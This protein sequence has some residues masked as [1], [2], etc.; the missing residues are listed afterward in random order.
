MNT[1]YTKKLIALIS[2][3]ILCI[4]IIKAQNVIKPAAVIQIQKTDPDQIKST[5]QK[6]PRQQNDFIENHRRQFLQNT[7]KKESFSQPNNFSKENY[8][9]KKTNGYSCPPRLETNFEGN[10]L[11]PFYLP[12][13]GYYASESSIAV[14]NSG[15]I[16]SISN[17]WIRYYNTDGAL[18]FSDSLYHFCSG[19]IDVRVMYDPQKDR[20]VFISAY[21]VTDFISLF[22]GYGIVAA[23]SK[24]SDPMDGWNFY[25]LPDSLSNDNSGSDYPQL[26]ISNDEVFIT[27][28]RTDEDGN[29]TH[30]R[31]IQVNKNEGYAG[32]ASL[33]MQTFSVALSAVTQGSVVP[34]SGGSKPYGPNM[35]FMMADETG[36]PDDIYHVFEI[37][38]TIA[39]G[40]AMLKTYG[41]VHS[42]ETY[43]PAPLSYQPGP[44]PL[45]EQGTE[46]GPPGIDDYLQNA[47]FE[48]GVLQFSQ[49]SAANGKA[50][51]CIGRINGIPN[52]L[53]CNTQTI[54]DL[55]LSLLFPQIAYTGN[56]CNDN[57]FIVGIEYTGEKKY[58]GLEAVSVDNYFSVSRPTIVK[59]GED[60]INGLWGD[61]SGICR[62]YNH[63]GECWMEGQYGSKIFPN[64]NWIAKLQ[65][66]LCHDANALLANNSSDLSSDVMAMKYSLSNYPNPFSN[67]A[68]I[69][70]SLAQSQKVSI[71]IFDMTGRLIKT[72]ADAQMEAGTH[73]LVW[74][75][76]DEKGNE[77]SSGLYF[78]RMQT[79]NYVETKKLSVLK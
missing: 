10:P 29:I 70:F 4:T 78:L 25:Y 50:A 62:R 44:L 75:A 74:N 40:K 69:S 33:K 48:N 38:N 6:S 28:L 8:Q 71:R 46:L 24:T 41:P 13:V 54:R 21:G 64:I 77:V 73:Q 3:S 27:D 9:D 59:H 61:Y 20:F 18:T 19:L 55:H 16:V 56:S 11:T 63:P 36:S 52:H 23:F 37:T 43:F 14:S 66:P 12:P 34:A 67:S 65:A 30:S 45:Y 39:S 2:V 76:R 22:Q 42:G 31:I 57:S 26:G 32:K 79:G 47:F 17:G 7:I 51:V 72:L 49:N 53:S 68:T 15:K 60:T 35:Y 58:P 5:L 1:F